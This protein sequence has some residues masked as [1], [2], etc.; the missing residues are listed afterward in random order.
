MIDVDKGAGLSIINTNREVAESFLDVSVT[1]RFGS[2]FLLLR[3]GH[4]LR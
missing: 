2:L 1:S 3:E 4:E